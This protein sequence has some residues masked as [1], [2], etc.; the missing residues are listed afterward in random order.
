M[1]DEIRWVSASALDDL[2][3]GD[4]LDVEVE[5]EQ[6][7][8]VHLL[9]GGVKAYQGMCPHQEILLAD[10]KVDWVE[11]RIWRTYPVKAGSP[12]RNN[13]CRQD[14]S[15]ARMYAL[16]SGS[17]VAVLTVIRV[18]AP[19]PTK[20]V[21]SRIPAGCTACAASASRSVVLSVARSA[22]MAF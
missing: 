5:G 11:F 2:W 20:D 3:E 12:A 16:A 13:R 21:A 4:L 9:E 15:W 6:V 17:L 1:S 18:L 7:M 14:V 8:L 10:G 19:R 22:S